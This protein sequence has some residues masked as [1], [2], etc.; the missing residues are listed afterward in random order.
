MLSSLLDSS[1]TN[2]E[3]SGMSPFITLSLAI[4]FGL[5]VSILHLLAHPIA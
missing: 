5:V 2:A 3:P 1:S 4:A